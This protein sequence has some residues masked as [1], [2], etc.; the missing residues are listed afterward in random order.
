M[1]KAAKA[2][3][4]SKDINRVLISRYLVRI[5]GLGVAESLER[6]RESNPAQ[7]VELHNQAKRFEHRLK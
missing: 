3:R 7:L 2:R 6:I 5:E 1:G 4:V